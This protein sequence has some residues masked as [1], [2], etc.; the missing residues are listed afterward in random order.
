MVVAN[1]RT[2][3]LVPALGLLTACGG[4]SAS[5]TVTVTPAATNL[6]TCTQ[7]A[8]TA[9]I[10]GRAATAVQWSVSGGGSV[11]GNGLYTAPLQVP[12][13]AQ[14]SVNATAEGAHGAG[15][16]T[17][18]TALPQP[19]VSPGMA[20]DD[21]LFHHQMAA[22]GKRVYATLV[23]IDKSAAYRYALWVATSDD[24]GATFGAP[25]EASDVAD[26]EVALQAPAIAVDAGDANT[27][28]VSY[29]ID[30]GAIQHTSD[31]AA[32]MSGQTLALAVSTDGGKTFVNHVLESAVSGWQEYADVA[33]PAPGVV[34]VEAP[35]ALQPAYLRTYVDTARGAGF[36][37]VGS[38]YAVSGAHDVAAAPNGAPFGPLKSDGG[39]AGGESPRVFGDGK[40]KTCVTY[41]GGY[42][43]NQGDS[44]LRVAVQCSTDM[45]ATFSSPVDIDYE[46]SGYELH[47]PVGVFSPSGE[48]TIAYWSQNGGTGAVHLATS[49]DGG[50]SFGAPVTV[51]TYEVPTSVGLPSLPQYP[52]IAWDGGTLWLSYLVSDGNGNHRL[53]VD[54]SCDG[55]TT[56]SGAQLLNGAEPTIADDYQWPGLVLANGKPLLFARKGSAGADNLPYQVLELVP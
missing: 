41:V 15:M 50:A 36:T 40:G 34:V 13:P 7:Q 28:Y 46:A 12:N 31:A 53:V 51:P 26:P 22:S 14:L 17:L 56:W 52:A 9:Q 55:G 19:A 38:G 1:R 32:P 4:G 39:S 20:A 25:V 3:L 11:D 5:K 43:A 18:F 37:P 54:K 8:F 29:T 6:L 24:G 42:D 21:W 27:V 47:H 45:G 49:H 44:R 35:T 48:L 10:D 30:A 33:S 23:T 16:V 2:G